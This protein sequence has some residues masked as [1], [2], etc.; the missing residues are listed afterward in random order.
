MVHKTE[1][2]PTK[3]QSVFINT[4]LTKMMPRFR[5]IF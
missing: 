5:R 3:K 4:V 1:H 2:F